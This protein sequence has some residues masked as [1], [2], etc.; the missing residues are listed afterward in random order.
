MKTSQEL[1]NYAPDKPISFSVTVPG[2]PANPKPRTYQ[3]LAHVPPQYDHYRDYPL[4]LTLPGGRQT[5]QQHLNMWCGSYNSRL[6][7]RNGHAMRHGYIVVAVDWRD[8]GQSRWGYTRREHAIVIKA[9][10]ESFRKFSINSDRVFLSGCLLYTSD[11][12]DE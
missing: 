6:K 3:C 5:L 11:A 2:T 1:A 9:L 4:I 10:R 7:I 8:P 12:A